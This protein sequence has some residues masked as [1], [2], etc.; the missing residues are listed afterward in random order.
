MPLLIVLPLQEPVD[1]DVAAPFAKGLGYGVPSGLL[2]PPAGGHV[3]VLVM[4]NF[5]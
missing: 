5:A 4:N 3:S 1:L 2:Q